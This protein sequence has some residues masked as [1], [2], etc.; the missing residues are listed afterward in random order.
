MK[1]ALRVIG[2]HHATYVEEGCQLFA[3]RITRYNPF[4]VLVLP[5]V[6]QAGQLSPDQLK[7]KEGTLILEKLAPGD[8]LWLLD[9]K[10]KRFD[11]AGFARFLQE[12]L[13]HERGRLIFLIGGAYGFDET[14]Y[15]QAQGRLSLSDMTMNHQLVRI[16]FLEQLYRGFTILRNEPYHHA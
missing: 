12:R 10:G 16:V 9:E 11:S 8:S 6:K 15:K 2:K 13:L 7:K 5:D 1:I 3:Q 4:E 14:V